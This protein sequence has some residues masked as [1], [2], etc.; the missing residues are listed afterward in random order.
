M[1]HNPRQTLA[2]GNRAIDGGAPVWRTRC[3]LACEPAY[4]AFGRVGAAN[5]A[6]DKTDGAIVA[7]TGSTVGTSPGTGSCSKELVPLAL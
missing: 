4:S 6:G 2:G 7:S 5:I 1:L 3:I